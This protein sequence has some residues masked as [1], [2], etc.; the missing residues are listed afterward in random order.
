MSTDNESRLI[1]I[2]LM[3]QWA[4]VGA[5]FNVAPATESVDLELLVIETARVARGDERL[6]VMAA[7]WLAEHHHLLDARRLARRLTLLEGDDSAVAGAML[8]MALEGTPSATALEAVVKY[9]RP[10]TTRTLLFPVIAE[11]PGLPE[12]V[13]AE[14]LPLFIRWGFWHNDVTL[15]RNA[16]R[17]AAWLVRECP[18]LRVRAL[19]GPGLD[20]EVVQLAGSAP[21]SAADMASMAGVTYA[22]A[23]AAVSRLLGRGVLVRTR[24]GG[25]GRV[26]GINHAFFGALAMG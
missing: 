18:E 14:A 5:L 26:V 24:A 15:K 16:I 17:P 23:H 4:R 2:R 21:R 8:A 25:R 22:A 12:I 1:E 10:T 6:F 20:A 9:C 7:S 11:I 19:F 13:Q 3:Q